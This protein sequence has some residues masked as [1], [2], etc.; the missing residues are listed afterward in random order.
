[1]AVL[2]VD[3]ACRSWS[4]L[5][6]VL[7]EQKGTPHSYQIA[8]EI[9]RWQD[10]TA[11]PVV[12]LALRLNTLC[13]ERGASVL[14][15][16]GPQAWKAEDNGH[17]FCR[18][19][20]R[21][22]N[23]SAKTGLPGN[24]LPGTYE[25]FVG[26]CLALYDAL[27]RLGWQRLASRD[28]FSGQAIARAVEQGSEAGGNPK[29]LVESYPHAAWKSLGI[30]PLPSKR[31]C[32]VSHLAEAYASLTAM[33]PITTSQPPNHDQLQ[34]IVGGLPGLAIEASAG[35]GVS[36]LSRMGTRIVGQPPR[37]E[38]G[39]WREGFIVVPVAPASGTVLTSLD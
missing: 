10:P 12:E 14:M 21:E 16:D 6:V 2:S 25:R 7:L 28:P 26:Y 5:G 37:Q 9:I 27:G 11:P 35:L 17:E 18:A 33:L 24:V 15:L 23:T 3:L 4:D 31:R 1:M 39:Y 38:G 32:R 22:L 36:Q 19:S 34:A 29:I 8:C 30:Q 20:E 13:L